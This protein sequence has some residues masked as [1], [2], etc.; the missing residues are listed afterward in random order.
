MIFVPVR[1]EKL[2]IDV[3]AMVDT[4]APWCVIEGALASVLVDLNAILVEQQILSSRLGNYTGDLPH[5]G[6]TSR[7]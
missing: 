1:L 6:H 4:A 2:D 5:F 3:T 7:R